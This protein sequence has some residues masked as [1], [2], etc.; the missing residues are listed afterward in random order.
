MNWRVVLQN[1]I[2]LEIL[3]AVLA[4]FAFEVMLSEVAE[5]PVDPAITENLG[6]L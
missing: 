1:V 5:A 4:G 3:L 6:D 2:L